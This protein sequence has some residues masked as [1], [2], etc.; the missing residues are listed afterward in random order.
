MARKKAVVA[1]FARDRRHSLT[2]G[3]FVFLRA[4]ASFIDPHTV[5]L[6]HAIG[7][8]PHTVKSRNFVLATGSTI[9]PVTLPGLHEIGFLTSEKV[10]SFS[11]LPRSL[12]VLGGGPVAVELAQFLRRFDVEVT[13]LQR[14][15]QLLRDFD[16][17]GAEVVEKALRREGVRIWKGATLLKGFRQGRLKAIAFQHAGKTKHVVAEDIL[18][19]LGRVA[20]TAR[21]DLQNAGVKTNASSPTSKCKPARPIYMRPAIAPG[22]IRLSIPPWSRARLRPT[23]SRIPTPGAALITAC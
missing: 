1:D 13:L 14:S 4:H 6:S 16:P 7:N 9:S 23:T 17:D 15:D 5:A 8:A 2:T 3:K 10:L 21:L 12:I 18:F 19:A 11:K 22:R 20:A